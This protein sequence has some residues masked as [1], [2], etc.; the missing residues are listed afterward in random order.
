MGHF[1]RHRV[2][3]YSDD[4]PRDETGKWSGSGGAS[5]SSGQHSS[6]YE[7]V[8]PNVGN[9]DFAGA[10]TGLNSV[11]QS[12]LLKAS[13]EVDRSLGIDGTDKSIIGAWADGAENSVMTTV[14]NSDFNKLKVAA[15]MKGYL[16]DQ[17]QV[18]VFQ[19]DP[20]GQADLMSFDAKGSLADIHS[21]LIKDG[22]AFHTL[23]PNE[24]GTGAKVYVVDMD[25]SNH[26]SVKKGAARYDSTISVQTGHAEF[27]G[28]TKEDG[29]DREQRDDARA[30]YEGVIGRS[31]IQGAS[32][33]W[34]GIHNRYGKALGLP[35]TAT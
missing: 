11:R 8:S 6:G 7:F 1:E 23:V 4:Q 27:I 2:L 19:E 21:N 34:Q 14:Q 3:K 12:A 25:G 16:A 35:P 5:A 10:A 13:S 26:E 9:L 22:V 30:T 20:A 32:A 33:K 24:D 28:T 29:S 17:K 15:S 18:L 31:G